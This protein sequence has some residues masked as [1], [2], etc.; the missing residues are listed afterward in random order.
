MR[1][2][3]PPPRD[4]PGCRGVSGP[5]P[6]GENSPIHPLGTKAW[7]HLTAEDDDVGH[8]RRCV[9]GSWLGGA[10]WLPVVPHPVR[11]STILAGW[12]PTPYASALPSCCNLEIYSPAEKK[13]RR[14]IVALAVEQSETA[15]R[16]LV[17][18]EA[19]DDRWR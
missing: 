8:G 5:A 17:D 10:G 9:P 1:T 12:C 16:A 11:V 19:R 6:G 13:L 2:P 14:D 4:L 15:I 7:P 18:R 3:G